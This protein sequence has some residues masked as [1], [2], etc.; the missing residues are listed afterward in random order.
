MPLFTM[1]KGFRRR[2]IG[3]C[4]DER[5]S[6]RWTTGEEKVKHYDVHGGWSLAFCSE[7][8]STLAGV[9]EGV[10]HGITLGT[11][12]GDPKVEIESHIYVE[13]KAPWDHIGGDAPQYPEGLQE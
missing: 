9:L 8:G 6:H 7:C 1:P 4:S 10:V 3:L 2:F 11:V 13:S 12:N 5:N